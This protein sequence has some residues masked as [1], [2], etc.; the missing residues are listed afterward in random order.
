MQ[1]RMVLMMI[2]KPTYD[3]KKL[4][5]LLFIPLVFGCDT[6]STE[7]LAEEVKASIS[8]TF[9]ETSGLEDTEIIEF[10]LVHKGGNEYQGLLKVKEPNL[11]GELIDAFTDN[12]SFG[13]TIEKNY[14][15]EV[16]YD[17]EN[18]QWRIID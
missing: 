6:I 10:G 2:G 7:E 14:Q 18:I 9:K 1:S 4:I 15:V 12:D 3:M 13:D 8:E 11:F 5:L 17:G 16:I